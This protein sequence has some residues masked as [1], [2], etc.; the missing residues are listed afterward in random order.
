MPYFPFWTV[1]S[2]AAALGG[3]V[4]YMKRLAVKALFCQ[5]KEKYFF[6]LSSN[7]ALSA[8]CFI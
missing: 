2:V 3:K 6:V 1:A 4:S 5:N 8:N 7:I